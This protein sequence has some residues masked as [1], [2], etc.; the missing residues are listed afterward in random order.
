MLWSL[1]EQEITESFHPQALSAICKPRDESL[2]LGNLS[3]KFVKRY[4]GIE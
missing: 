1:P 3:D 4:F 2:T